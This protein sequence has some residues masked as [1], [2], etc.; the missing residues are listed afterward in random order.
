MGDGVGVGDAGNRGETGSRIKANGAEQREHHTLNKKIAGGATCARASWN[1]GE[2]GA[3]SRETKMAGKRGPRGRQTPNKKARG[4]TRS[5]RIREHLQAEKHS[6]TNASRRSRV[7]IEEPAYVAQDT[8]PWLRDV[9]GFKGDGH[10]HGTGLLALERITPSPAETDGPYALARF[11]RATRGSAAPSTQP[12]GCGAAGR[13]RMPATACIAAAQLGVLQ[14][15][16]NAMFRR[17]EITGLV[18]HVTRSTPTC[19]GARGRDGGSNEMCEMLGAGGGHTIELWWACYRVG[20]SLEVG[21]LELSAASK[22]RTQ[23]N[24]EEMGWDAMCQVNQRG[25][26]SPVTG[27]PIWQAG[28]NRLVTW[29]QGV[30]R[31]ARFLVVLQRQ[32]A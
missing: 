22:A 4:A 1:V 16:W 31:G 32:R 11:V 27:L 24:D 19:V 21:W 26:K 14:N 30:A 10:G 2:G 23:R 9:C 8:D 29:P 15:A 20:R 12:V 7:R 17:R 28:H 25:H 13:V 18:I 3:A 6:A 5:L